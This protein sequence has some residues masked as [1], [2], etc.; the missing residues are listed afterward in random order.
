MTDVPRRAGDA[1]LGAVLAGGA[2]R[3]FGSPKWSAEL[4]G[5]SMGARAVAALEPNTRVVVA[6]SSDPAV[7][8]LGVDVRPDLLPGNGPLGA[9]HTALACAAERSLEGAFL[10]ACDLP[11]VDAELVRALIDAWDGE[12]AVVPSGARGPEPLCALYG[13]SLLAEVERALAH[14]ELAVHRL[15]ARARVCGFATERARA[16]SGIEDPFLNVNTREDHARAELALAR[17]AP[18]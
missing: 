13:V 14:G 6:I 7:A 5:R 4:A 1:L 18:Q 15:L 16:L 17:R 2:S 11:L 12:D 8:G 3:R 9:I 10:L